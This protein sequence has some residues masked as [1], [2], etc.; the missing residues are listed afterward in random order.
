MNRGI[1]SA[2]RR[3]WTGELNLQGGDEEGII[4]AR[5]RA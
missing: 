3:A 1:K 5:R 2:R 4:S